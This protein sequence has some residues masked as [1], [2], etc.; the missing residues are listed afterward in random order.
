MVKETREMDQDEIE[1]NNKLVETLI[2]SAQDVYITERQEGKTN[3]KAVEEY[4][5]S[6]REIITLRCTG[7]SPSQLAYILDEAKECLAPNLEYLRGLKI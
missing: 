5:K 6:A 1:R 2:S 3:V 7:V 4:S